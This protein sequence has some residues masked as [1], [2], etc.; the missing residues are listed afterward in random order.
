MAG[1][2]GRHVR[3]KYPILMLLVAVAG[4]PACGKDVTIDGVTV[5]LVPPPGFCELDPAQHNDARMLAAIEGMLKGTNNKVLLAGADCG[6]LTEWRDA[7]RPYIDHLVQYQTLHEYD[8]VANRPDI[9]AVCEAMRAQGEQM[10]SDDL[11]RVRARTEEIMKNAKFNE[12]KFLGVLGEE[13]DACYAALLQ[14]LVSAAG[15][16][17]E[18]VNAFFTGLLRGKY[19]YMYLTAPYA[20][21]NTVVELTAQLKAQLARLR[22]DNR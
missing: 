13:P 21:G 7:R 12:S 6:E 16:A 4:G 3:W 19:V 17:K 5:T 14:K 18:Q 8:Y 2:G 11:P 22:T 1:F 20:D 15:A 10:A 9:H